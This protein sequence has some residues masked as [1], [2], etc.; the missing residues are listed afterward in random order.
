LKLLKKGIYEPETEGAGDKL[1]RK[2]KKAIKIS[3]WGLG[4]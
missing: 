2:E 3:T 4:G 1:N